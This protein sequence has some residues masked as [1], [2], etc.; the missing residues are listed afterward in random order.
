[1]SRFLV[2]TPVPEGIEE[3][4]TAFGREVEDRFDEFRESRRRLGVTRDTGWLQWTPSGNVFL[5]LVE[6][7]DPIEAN[8]R[9]A[10]SQEPFDLWFKERA[11]RIFG[12]DFNQPIPTRGAAPAPFSSR[13]RAHALPGVMGSTGRSA[14]CR[15]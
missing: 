15:S 8:R 3:D 12:A 13:C 6:G 11:G 9:F 10:A 1:M 7:A 2:A 14:G 5:L 4:A